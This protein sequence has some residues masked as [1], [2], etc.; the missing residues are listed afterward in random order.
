MNGQY[1][2]QIAR[3]GLTNQSDSGLN[4][5]N[6]NIFSDKPATLYMGECDG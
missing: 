2:L 3:F 4:S 1:S 6:W 5:G